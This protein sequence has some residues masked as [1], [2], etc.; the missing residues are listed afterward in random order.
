MP[1]PKK[2]MPTTRWS[3]SIPIDVAARVELLL[4]DIFKG[5]VGYGER[6]ELIAELLRRWLER[7][8]R[9]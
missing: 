2:A 9:E 3:I 4:T 5:S 7:Q 8:G 1:R 6:S